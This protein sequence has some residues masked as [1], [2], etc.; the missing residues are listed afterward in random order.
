MFW[1]FT[2]ICPVGYAIRYGIKRS[3]GSYSFSLIDSHVRNVID[4]ILVTICKCTA[5]WTG[6]PNGGLDEHTFIRRGERYWINNSIDV[7]G[8]IISRIPYFPQYTLG[9]LVTLW[10]GR[11]L[12]PQI[13]R[14]LPVSEIQG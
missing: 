4:V 9:C 1:F 7:R 5:P 6:A 11:K 12:S 8:A 2:S 3:V 13:L 14:R 10:K